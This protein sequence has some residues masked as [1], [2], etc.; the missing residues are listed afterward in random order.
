MFNF[1]SVW[2]YVLLSTGLLF[3]NTD[4]LTVFFLFASERPF[5]K[6]EVLEKH[7]PRAQG[8]FFVGHN[9]DISKTFYE[10]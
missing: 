5:M 8:V 9:F 4:V 10:R 6:N 2:R 7:G 3:P 1:L